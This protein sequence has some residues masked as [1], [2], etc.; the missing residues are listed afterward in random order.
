MHTYLFNIN[1]KSKYI[2][3]CK[4]STNAKKPQINNFY[5][6]I[7]T[8]TINNYYLLFLKKVHT[9][10]ACIET[11]TPFFTTSTKEICY[12]VYECRYLKIPDPNNCRKLNRTFT[13]TELR[14]EL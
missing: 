14:N 1:L 13:I 3:I 4:T 10:C 6:F 2:R 8:V 7:E 11:R 12:L 5:L 9:Q